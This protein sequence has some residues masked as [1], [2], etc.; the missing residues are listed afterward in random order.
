M[1]ERVL[2][3][4]NDFRQKFDSLSV[5]VNGLES[6]LKYA[7]DRLKPDDLSNRLALVEEYNRI[8]QYR[9]ELEAIDK[10]VRASE[11]AANW[12]DKNRAQLINYARGHIFCKNYTLNKFTKPTVNQELINSFCQDLD[13]YFRWIAHHLRMGTRPQNLASGVIELLLPPDTYIEAFKI[14]RNNKVL[15][16]FG[17][18][19]RAVTM[20]RSSINR[21][22]IKRK[23][24]FD[25]PH[26]K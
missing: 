2:R 22:L 17:L 10:D 16:T 25:S 21:F 20:L 14:I 7:I 5:L 1:E 6:S 9:D 8:Q 24:E 11:E 26:S 19:K 4:E 3:L 15:E 12:L 23:L 13:S 18:S